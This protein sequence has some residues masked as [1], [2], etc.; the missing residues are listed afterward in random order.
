VKTYLVVAV[1]NISSLF[2]YDTYNEYIVTAASKEDAES[3]C[4]AIPH[5]K[6]VDDI[7]DISP[8]AAEALKKINR[9][10]EI[11]DKIT[12]IKMF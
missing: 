6:D 4:K 9:T 11:N 3:M 2:I 10:T 1:T 8:E 5:F 7:R 12:Q